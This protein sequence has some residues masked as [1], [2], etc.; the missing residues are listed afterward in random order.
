MG[1]DEN[2]GG[3]AGRTR[4]GA[5][6]TALC[7]AHRLEAYAGRHKAGVLA[8]ALALSAALNVWQL[9]HYKVERLKVERRCDSLYA[10]PSA[11]AQGVRHRCTP[12]CAP[13]GDDVAP[14]GDDV[15]LNANQLNYYDH[16][17]AP[18]A[19]GG[20]EATKNQ[21]DLWKRKIQR[22]GMDGARGLTSW[23]C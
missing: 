23:G 18:C 17:L 22:T 12:G 10:R 9:V 13:Y 11:W 6:G 19:S 15:A 1:K 4:N 3:G 7:A 2:M 8:A 16:G 5:P 20:V 14:Y 21:L